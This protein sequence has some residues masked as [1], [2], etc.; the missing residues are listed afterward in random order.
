MQDAVSRLYRIRKTVTKMLEDRGYLLTKEESEFTLES[1]KTR[2]NFHDLSPNEPPKR[3]L[4]TLLTRKKDDPMDKI[5][6]FF[7]DELKMGVKTIRRYCER[8]KEESVGR[9]VIVVQGTMTPFAKSSL[10]SMLPK[11]VLEHFTETEL[12][13]NI[14]EHVLV[15]RHILLTPDEKRQLLERYNLK[16][17]QLPRI[18]A[19]DPVARYYG[20][21]RG[22]VV[23]IIRPSETAGRY[24]TY[25]LVV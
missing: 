10:T 21:K 4:L 13:V 8:M 17:T 15:P 19:A 11:Y 1:F 3:D 14:T 22:E 6:V 23:K 18:Q 12:L 5:F 7:P 16:D 20:L 25:R 2:F 9:S 24:V